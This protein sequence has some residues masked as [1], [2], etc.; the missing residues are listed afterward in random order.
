[1]RGFSFKLRF[2]ILV[3]K[4]WILILL[5]QYYMLYNV[6]ILLTFVYRRNPV[7]ISHSRI[8]VVKMK[9]RIW[10]HLL[11]EEK[12]QVPEDLMSC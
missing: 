4:Y 12:Q 5:I 10:R 6:F 1:M 7:A 8:D 9:N 3:H 11:V 2:L